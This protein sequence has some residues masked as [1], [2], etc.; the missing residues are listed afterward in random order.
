MNHYLNINIII[1]IDI[2]MSTLNYY[3]I[4]MIELPALVYFNDFNS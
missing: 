3:G 4:L 2:E 1:V